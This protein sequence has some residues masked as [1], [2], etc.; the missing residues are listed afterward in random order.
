MRPRKK[1]ARLPKASKPWLYGSSQNQFD[2]DAADDVGSCEDDRQQDDSTEEDQTQLAIHLLP[3]NLL[4]ELERIS[5][6]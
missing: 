2:K 4:Q 1:P 5:Q 3:Q 6:Q